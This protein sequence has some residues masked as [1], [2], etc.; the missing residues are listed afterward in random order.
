MT[1]PDMCQLKISYT[2][3]RGAEPALLIRGAEPALPIR[4][5]RYADAALW[6][7]IG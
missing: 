5:G 1:E 3:A 2:P 4:G 6:A 7:R